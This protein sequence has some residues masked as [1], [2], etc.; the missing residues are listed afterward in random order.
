MAALVHKIPGSKWKQCLLFPVLSLTFVGCTQTNP[1]QIRDIT[2]TALKN[3]PPNVSRKYDIP[4]VNYVDNTTDTF[5]STS[6][7][8]RTEH[9]PTIIAIHEK[10]PVSVQH[11]KEKRTIKTT[12]IDR[13][14]YSR[15]YDDIP[16]GGYKGNSYKVQHG[17]TL[18]YIAWITGNDY[19]AL[20]LQNHIRKPYDL[21]VGQ[22]LNVQGNTSVLVA[23]EDTK[24]VVV[25]KNRV[26][27]A[28]AI[29]PLP[30]QRVQ[31]SMANTATL[32][33]VWPAQGKLLVPYSINSK[34]IDIAGK[35]GDKVVAA[36]A[37]QVVYAGNALP[38]YGNLIIIKHSDDYLTAYAHNQQLLVKEQQ[39]VKGGEQIATLGSTGTSSPRLHFEIRYK[40]KSVDPIKYLPTVSVD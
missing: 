32:Q 9:V 22:I 23:K 16:K 34:G 33:W 2:N 35:S 18:F 14:V 40:A 26:K 8:L 13:I 24:T 15:N 38:G 12:S 30:P 1:A 28:K 11:Y 7:T 19:R 25:P 21:R 3:K 5:S 6:P 31:A 4:V 39:Y 20:A 37:G 36:S 10:K 17:D 29:R 27:Q